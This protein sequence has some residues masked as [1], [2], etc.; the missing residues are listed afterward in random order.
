MRERVALSL[1]PCHWYSARECDWARGERCPKRPAFFRCRV[2]VK[3]DGDREMQIHPKLCNQRAMA[4]A[5]F[6]TASAFLLGPSTPPLMSTARRLF[7]A[8]VMDEQQQQQKRTDI[9]V[10]LAKT[11][12]DKLKGRRPP[13]SMLRA[14]ARGG[15]LTS[16]ERN[17]CAA[18]TSTA[19][20]A[21]RARAG[22]RYGE[23]ER[24]ASE[25][26]RRELAAA[27][28]WRGG[29][30]DRRRGPSRRAARGRGGE[31]H[32][33]VVL[34]FKRDGCPACNSTIAP[35]PP[36]PKRTRGVLTF[37]RWI[38]TRGRASAVGRRSRS[39]RART[40]MS[41]A[42]CSRPCRWA[43]GSGR[44]CDAY[45]GDCR[46]AGWGGTGGGDPGG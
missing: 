18:R 9:D 33:A 37:A 21:L 39:S 40:Y 19:A 17:S 10:T 42:S 8:V 28:S 34:K 14:A 45:G 6:V 1:Q 25:L 3:I 27:G 36:P 29:R 13:A 35:S 12:L 43:Q 32:R 30:A 26:C 7:I 4:F 20:I 16:S 44:V 22:S 41:T 24:K 15:A 23:A 5:L 2:R 11:S 38:T 31:W 46:P